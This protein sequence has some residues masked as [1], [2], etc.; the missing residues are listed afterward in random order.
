MELR[1]LKCGN[2]NLFRK[3][4]KDIYYCV[5]CGSE[6]T[7]KRLMEFIS[8]LDNSIEKHKNIWTELAEK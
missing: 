3:I 1:C 4:D 7:A 5:N 8:I 2:K 6:F